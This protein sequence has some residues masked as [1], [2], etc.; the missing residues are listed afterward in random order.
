M[1]LTFL[2]TGASEGI[3]SLFCPCPLCRHAREEGGKDVRHRASALVNQDLLID[4]SPDTFSRAIQLGLDF[5]SLQHLLITHTHYDHFY[6]RELMNLIPPRAA[7]PDD[8]RLKILSSGNTMRE[9][10]HDLPP[11]HMKQLTPHIEFVELQAFAPYTAGDYTI[12][13]LKARHG[14]PLPLIY[15]I[16]A[17]GKRILYATDS[18]FFPEETWDCIAGMPFDLVILDCT[19]ADGGSANHMSIEDNFTVKKRLYQQKNI[20]DG[21]PVLATHFSHENGLDHRALAD[22][23]RI[24]GILPAWD[25]MAQEL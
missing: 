4:L 17:G 11:R 14:T 21:T 23:L 1:K 12:L 9:L 6:A 16:E 19:F 20:S 24:Y 7:L 3:P 10:L 13:P 18:G 8:F 22:R 25:G 5:S 2:G 15:S